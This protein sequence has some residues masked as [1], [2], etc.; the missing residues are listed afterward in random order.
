MFTAKTATKKSQFPDIQHDTISRLT[1]EADDRIARKAGSQ[2]L[3][4]PL[5]LVVSFGSVALIMG[6][7]F[8]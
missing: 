6:W 2:T 8:R 7:I 5:R 3:Q 1:A 4:K